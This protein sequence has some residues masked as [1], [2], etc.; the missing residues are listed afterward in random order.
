MDEEQCF[1]L[2]AAVATDL[3]LDGGY[4]LQADNLSQ[5]TISPRCRQY[6]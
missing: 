6:D 5:T 3:G 4:A 2:T 1:V